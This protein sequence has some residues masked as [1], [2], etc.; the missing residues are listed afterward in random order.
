MD[1]FLGGEGELKPAESQFL[2][3]S[4]LAIGKT[5][6]PTPLANWERVVAFILA[7]LLASAILV[8]FFFFVDS[9]GIMGEYVFKFL[10]P[11]TDG[12]FLA[13]FDFNAIGDPRPRVL[14]TFLTYVNISLRQFLLL[15]GPIHP[16]LGVAWLLYPLCII[17]MFKVTARLTLDRRSALIAAIIFAVSPA[18]LDTLNN[19]YV[20]AK[21]LANVMMLMAIYGACL[22]FPARNADDMSR[23]TLGALVIFMSGLSGLLTDETAIFIYICVPVLFIDRFFD[24]GIPAGTKW[25]FAASLTSSLLAYAMLAFAA[26]PALNLALGQVPVDLWTVVTRGVYTEMFLTPN[27]PVGDLSANWFA[28]RPVADLITNVSPVA[29]LETILSAHAVPHRFVDHIWTS[30]TP[31]PHFTHWRLSDQLGLFAFA[32]ILAYFVFQARRE[33]T[34]LHLLGRI[35][36]AFGVFVVVESILLLRLAPWIVEVNYYAAFSSLFFALIFGILLSGQRE[37]FSA[38]AAWITAVYLSTVQLANYYETA[39]RHPSIQKSQLSWKQLREVHAEVAAGQFGQIAI[40]HAFPSRL[41]AIGLEQAV[42]IEHAAGRPVD[43]RPTQGTDATIFRFVG[44]NNLQDPNIPKSEILPR[45][46]NSLAG[47]AKEVSGHDLSARLAGHAIRGRAGGWEFI[48]H[49]SPT[50]EIRERMWRPGVM[51]VW[52]RR[53]KAVVDGDKLCLEFH[54]YP[55]ECIARS[56]NQDATTYGFSEDGKLIAAF[57]WLPTNFSLPADLRN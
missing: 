20:P 38:P 17:L 42:A 8:L 2:P 40:A 21:A 45:D 32:A 4:K 28:G 56:Y 3:G 41:F 14:T 12:G 34:R 6:V 15:R 31:L 47:M 1:Y 27:Q 43:L 36:L 22:M 49:F 5:A 55:R 25:A 23:P 13:I 39:Q 11:I 30:G 53:G 19:Y 57:D 46:E 35:A 18:M 51:R 44:L 7:S 37:Q 9:S 24:R 50:G 16:S 54:S 48:G 52:G 29:L 26:V 33:P 10:P